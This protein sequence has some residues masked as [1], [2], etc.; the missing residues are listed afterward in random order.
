M[1]S[2]GLYYSMHCVFREILINYRYQ[3]HIQ[4]SLTVRD[5]PGWHSWLDRRIP[6]GSYLSYRSLSWRSESM[7]KVHEQVASYQ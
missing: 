5:R 3:H 4:C 6:L 1:N 7:G 2:D